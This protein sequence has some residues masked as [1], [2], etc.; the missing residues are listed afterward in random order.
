MAPW[1]GEWEWPDI[2]RGSGLCSSLFCSLTR[3][4]GQHCCKEQLP[5]RRDGDAAGKDWSHR[6]QS[7]LLTSESGDTVPPSTA[8]LQLPEQVVEEAGR[9]SRCFCSPTAPTKA[10]ETA[11]LCSNSSRRCLFPSLSLSPY[12]ADD[13]CSLEEEERVI[14]LR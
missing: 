10:A 1:L 11:V 5:L 12:A 4:S 9:R 14:C 3:A 8:R 7:C 2:Q 6:V 13:F